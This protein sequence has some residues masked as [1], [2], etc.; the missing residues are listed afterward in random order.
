[1]V[2]FETEISV[3][4]ARRYVAVA[5]IDATGAILVKSKPLKV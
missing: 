3:P 2:G 5:A 1:M 4:Q